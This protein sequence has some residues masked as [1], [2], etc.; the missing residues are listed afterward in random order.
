MNKINMSDQELKVDNLYPL[1]ITEYYFSLIEQNNIKDDPIAKQCIPHTQ[2]LDNFV[3]D[4]F[5]PLSEKEQMPVSKL[6]H[7]YKDRVVLLATNH[8]NVHCRFCFRKRQWKKGEKL[9][10]IT[11]QEL[12]NIANYLKNHPEVKEVLVS[13]GDPLTLKI[14]Q[15][16][17]ILNKIN[18][19]SNIEVIRICTRTPVTDPQSISAELAKM[20][21]NFKGIWIVTH[22]NHPNEITP[23][24]MNACEKFIKCGIPIVNQTVLLK[25]V[26]DEAKILELLFRELI[27]NQIKP[28]YLFHIDP[29]QSVKHFS[30]G[31]DV[32]LNILRELRKNLSS[33]AIPTY[34]IDLPKGGGKVHLQPNYKVNNKFESINGE[35]I[36]Y[37]E[38]AQKT[39]DL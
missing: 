4:S 31:I 38:V 16:E 12:A 13:G 14:S 20:L 7:K 34:A 15:L 9:S 29:V 37:I 1:K 39:L 5:D 27:K 2:E 33:L 6:I 32:G 25:G 17:T 10:I 36:D 30:T 19:I 11:N 35:L 8:C 23:F 24:S 18:E 22:F 3:S 26:N 21:S 28:Y